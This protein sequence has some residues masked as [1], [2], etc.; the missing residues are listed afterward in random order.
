MRAFVRSPLAS[1]CLISDLCLAMRIRQGTGSNEKPTL[2]HRTDAMT[3]VRSQPS[4]PLKLGIMNTRLIL[5][6]QSI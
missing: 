2:C 5:N 3:N 1:C 6:P 4:R